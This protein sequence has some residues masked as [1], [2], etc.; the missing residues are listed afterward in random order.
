MFVIKG[1]W[2]YDEVWEYWCVMIVLGVVDVRVV[3]CGVNYLCLFVIVVF[4]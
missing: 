2:V 4:V 3:I 1:E